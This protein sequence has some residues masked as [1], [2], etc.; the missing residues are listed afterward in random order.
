MSEFERVVV[1]LSL[2]TIM[3]SHYVGRERKN[4]TSRY[5]T[6]VDFTPVPNTYPVKAR[7]G[8]WD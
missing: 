3:E 8:C 6:W 2:N 5:G 4:D 7:H 1:S